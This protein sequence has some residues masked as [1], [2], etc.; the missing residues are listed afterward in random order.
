MGCS[1]YSFK[2]WKGP[3]YPEDLKDSEMLAYYATRLRTVEINNTFYRMPKKAVL[4]KWSSEVPET[5][6][7]VLKATRRITHI[8]RLKPE[9][10]DA[11]AFLLGNAAV[12][13]QR[14]GPFLFQLPGNFRCDLGRLH[15]FLE[16]LPPGTRA[17]FEFRH[18]SWLDDAVFEALRSRDLALCIADTDD[19]DPAFGVMRSTASWGYLRLRRAVYDAAALARWAHAIKAQPWREAYVFCKH[20]EDGAG[21][22]L[23][24]SLVRAL[25]AAS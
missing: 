6:R 23:A 7:F 5:F 21:P 1:G 19:E 14:L 25:D 10:A 3:F 13:G 24:A 16:M 18:P 2:E 12:M 20:E 17:A 15:A 9:G 11:L 22:E 8:T 4:E